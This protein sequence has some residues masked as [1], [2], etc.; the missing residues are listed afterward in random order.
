[1]LY[2]LDGDLCRE[3]LGS[4][5]EFDWNCGEFAVG[6]NVANVGA[7][8]FVLENNDG[9]NAGVPYRACARGLLGDC[10]VV[11]DYAVDLVTGGRGR[12][13]RSK[14]NKKGREEGE[15]EKAGNSRL[16]RLRLDL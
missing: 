12:Q 10:A 7:F 9:S 13:R 14:E 6:I 11:C 8:V 4:L 2:V 3:G 15:G 5:C 1:M 16:K